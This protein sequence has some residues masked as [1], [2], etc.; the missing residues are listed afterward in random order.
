MNSH[1]EEGFL[2]LPAPTSFGA[3]FAM[4]GISET[5]LVSICSVSAVNE[6]APQG[7]TARGPVQAILRRAVRNGSAQ[8]MH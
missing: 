8:D 4:E 2:I 5:F 6:N 7:L 1:T 3:G